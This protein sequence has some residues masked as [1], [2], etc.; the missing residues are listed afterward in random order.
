MNKL[1]KFFFCLASMA[2]TSLGAEAQEV[3]LWEGE[4]YLDWNNGQWYQLDAAAFADVAN[5][6]QLLVTFSDVNTA[7]SYPQFAFCSGNWTL[8]DGSSYTHVA[9]PS[10]EAL[11][12]TETAA[13][14]LLETGLILNGDGLTVS[15][16]SLK[17]VGD[18][19]PVWT[20]SVDLGNWDNWATIAHSCFN[21]A[22]VGDILRFQVENITAGSTFHLMYVSPS[23]SWVAYG[24]DDFDAYINPSSRYVDYVVN[25][26][27]LPILKGENGEQGIIVMGCNLTVTS[28][29]ILDPESIV[30]VNGTIDTA[31]MVFENEEPF[32]KFGLDGEGEM[33]VEIIVYDDFGSLV[34]Q[35]EYTVSAGEQTLPLSIGDNE[36]GV[37]RYELYANDQVIGGYNFVVNPTQIIAPVDAQADFD[38]FW[39]T[40]LDELATIDMEVNLIEQPDLSCEARKVYVV[41]LKS[42]PDVAG[43]EPVTVRGY[44]YEPTGDKTYPAIITYNGYYNEGDPLWISKGSDNPEWI[45]LNFYTRGQGYDALNGLNTEYAYDWFAYNFGERDSYYYRSAY[46]DVVRAIDFIA[47]REKVQA[48]NIFA[49]GQS[50][51]GAFTIAAAALDTRLNAIAPAVQFMGDFP[52]YFRINSFPGALAFANQGDMTDEEMYA[53]LSYFDT[54]NLAPRITCPVITSVSLQDNVCPLRTNLAPYNN[55]TVTERE[56][57]YNNTLAH[58]VPSSWYSDYFEFFKA[59]LG[60]S[61]ITAVSQES[62]QSEAA[63]YNLQGIR[64]ENPVKGQ[65]VI[66]VSGNKTE[67]IITR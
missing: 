42:I 29:A 25:E 38:Q 46:I 66:K 52:N 48:N 62:P 16:V 61:S 57:H 54:K 37:F 28:L 51:G 64:I 45:E 21:R 9:T 6:N 55:L 10:T 5:Y 15:K 49:Q 35:N 41:E 23:W 44:Y 59:H 65:I 50:Q 63:Y 3:T 24:D 53:F 58:A 11:W 14:E 18:D 43:G 39:Q 20:G 33:N 67:K 36:Q 34:S 31:K 7:C 26:N 32:V 12:L 1:Y 2:L 56:I 17:N 4:Q 40:A 60:S 19:E 8:L 27:V 30:E 13:Q 47:S 22:E